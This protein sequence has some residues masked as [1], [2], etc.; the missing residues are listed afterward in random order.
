M[1]KGIV[2][3]SLLGII[4]FSSPGLCQLVSSSGIAV[5]SSIAQET[6][7]ISC[8]TIKVIDGDTIVVKALNADLPLA[9]LNG[10]PFKVRLARVDAPELSQEFGVSSMSFLSS[11]LGTEEFHLMLS[12]KGKLQMDRYGR[13]LG[14]VQLFGY[15][16]NEQLVREGY[17][18]SYLHKD[19][20]LNE[21]E[22]K[23]EE[24]K[25]GLWSASNPESP[26]AYRRKVK[27]EFESRHKRS[28]KGFQLDL[29]F[30]GS[31]LKETVH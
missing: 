23:A 26:W 29:S 13:V 21:L 14:E 1:L 28:Y 5:L 12:K 31:G 9:Q 11:L 24:A 18:W 8:R 10:K 3:G 16:V 30:L 4:G 22:K 17:A 7:Y 20:K 2:I 25:I 15:S 19:R 27:K 6:G